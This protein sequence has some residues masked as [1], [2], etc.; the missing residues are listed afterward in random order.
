MEALE[1]QGR[2]QW[3][4]E[5]GRRLCEHDDNGTTGA[6]NWLHTAPDLKKRPY[7][8]VAILYAPST[9]NTLFLVTTRRHKKASL[10]DN[11]QRNI[12]TEPAAKPARAAP[13][14][15]PKAHNTDSLIANH[16]TPPAC[17]RN[18]HQAA[19]Q[20]PNAPHNPL[21]TQ[22]N[23]SHPGPSR[24]FPFWQEVL[25]CYVTNTNAEDDSGKAKCVPVLEDYYECLHHKKEVR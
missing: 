10:R 4:D 2:A 8:V 25:A 16:P 21:K 23:T 20:P 15:P 11:T 14:P 12:S 7:R 22:T 13:H 24:C 6:T 17:A 1:H 19:P 18:L 3:Q 5:H 9:G